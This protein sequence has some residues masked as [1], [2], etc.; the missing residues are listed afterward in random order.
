[1]KYQELFH[2]L[3]WGTASE[4]AEKVAEVSIAV[5]ERPFRAA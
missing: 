1:M 5:E 3:P 2:K 4:P